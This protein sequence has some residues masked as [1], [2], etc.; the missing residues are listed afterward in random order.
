MADMRERAPPAEVS[1]VCLKRHWRPLTWSQSANV[2]CHCCASHEFSPRL[3]LDL[4]KLGNECIAASY[5][6]GIHADIID[7]LVVVWKVAN[8]RM[9]RYWTGSACFFLRLGETHGKPCSFLRRALNM[10]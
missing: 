4:F 2:G 1:K 6:L 7:T 5:E 9:A 8:T 3:L 10:I